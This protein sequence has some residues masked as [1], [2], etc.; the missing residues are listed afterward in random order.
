MAACSCSLVSRGLFARTSAS[1]FCESAWPVLGE[2]EPAAMA[3]ESCSVHIRLQ[4]GEF[5]GRSGAPRRQVLLQTVSSTA[6]AL[7]HQ[8]QAAAGG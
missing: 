1:T 2:P 3:G 5:A 6:S 4:T 8:L 7:L